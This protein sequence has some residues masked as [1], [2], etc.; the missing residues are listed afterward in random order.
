MELFLQTGIDTRLFANA[1]L[2]VTA[3]NLQEP[4]EALMEFF[5]KHYQWANVNDFP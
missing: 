3:Q 1:I 4:P 5:Q 2:Q